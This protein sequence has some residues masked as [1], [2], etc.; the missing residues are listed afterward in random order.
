LKEKTGV[1]RAGKGGGQGGVIKIIQDTLQ[2]KNEAERNVARGPE[3]K[4]NKRKTQRPI[5]ASQ[6]TSEREGN[7]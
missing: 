5:R 3:R 6:E 1:V 2:F 4:G 7:I